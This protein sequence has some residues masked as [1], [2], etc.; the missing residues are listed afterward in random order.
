MIEKVKTIQDDIKDYHSKECISASGL[1][2]IYQKSLGHYLQKEYKK[3]PAMELGVQVHDILQIGL[4]EFHKQYFVLPK[5]DMR[6][7]KNK[8]FVEELKAKNSTKTEISN[9]NYKI[10]LAIYTNAKNNEY[11][12]PY[13]QGIHEMSHYGEY[14]GVPIRV[15]PDTIG[16]GWISDIKTC[17]DNSPYAFKS[18]INKYAYNVQAVFYCDMLAFDPKNFRFISAE[19][20]P[21]YHVDLHGLT[22]EQIN[23]GR[24][25]WKKAFYY[26]QKY[27][28]DGKITWYEGYERTED[29]AL[30]I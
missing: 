10:C 15:R 27:L 28:E 18:T 22:D 16:K 23:K 21:P 20:N 8:E 11:V 2:L 12:F 29:G 13:L 14:K 24:D 4:E 5:L 6:L 7:K 3:T 9:D 17:Q 30:V 1:K 25:G 26:W 19:T